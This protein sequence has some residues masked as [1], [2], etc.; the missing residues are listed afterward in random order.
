MM[1]TGTKALE[2]IAYLIAFVSAISIFVSLLNSLKQRKYELSLLRVLGGKSTS[3]LSLI[4]I[5]GLIMA[6]IGFLLGMFLSNIALS[7]LTQSLSDKYN[8]EFES[9]MLHGLEPKVFIGTILLGL[10]AAL[11]PAILAYKT[12]IHKNLSVG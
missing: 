11:I 9:W 8:Y 3:L 12:D 4:L 1:G 7:S 10:L 6:F 2:L 5:E